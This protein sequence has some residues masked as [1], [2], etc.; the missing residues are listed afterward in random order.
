MAPHTIYVPFSDGL[1]VKKTNIFGKSEN[2]TRA[3]IY[4]INLTGKKLVH[5]TARRWRTGFRKF[6]TTKKSRI[7]RV[8]W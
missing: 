4:T 5:S 6:S 1:G 7:G 3:G 8:P 2:L